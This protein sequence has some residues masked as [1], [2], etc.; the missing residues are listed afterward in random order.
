M[1][2]DSDEVPETAENLKIQLR[3]IIDSYSTLSLGEIAGVLDEL[4]AEI[5]EEADGEDD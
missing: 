5:E 2:N 3:D 4:T 1:D